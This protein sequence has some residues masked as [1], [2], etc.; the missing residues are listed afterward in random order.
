MDQKAIVMLLVQGSLILFMAA[1]GLRA[2]WRDVVA[3]LGNPGSLIR[4]VIAVNIVVP[5]VAIIMC[6]LL[7]IERETRIGIIV[8]AVSPLAPFI[9]AKMMKVGLT[10]SEAIGLYVSLALLS[11]IIVPVTVALLSAIY[12][13]DATISVGAVTKLVAVLVLLP[14]AVSLVISE[15]APGLAKRLAPIFLGVAV[16]VLLLFLVLVLYKQG[17][18]MI[19][20]IGDGTLL[21]IVVTVAAGLAAGHL[22]GGPRLADRESLAFAAATRHPGIAALIANANFHDPR[23]LVAIILFLLTSVVVSA[24][25]QQWVKRSVAKDG[26]AAP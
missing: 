9:A 23:V 24:I 7:P 15:V 10:A 4:G 20:L 1:I 13:A 14:L 6:S 21:A 11:V 3:S 12:P 17:G 2:R 5:L 8:M 26:S 18:H 25:Y 22:L 19:A 16:V